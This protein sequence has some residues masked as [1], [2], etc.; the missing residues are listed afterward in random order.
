MRID[1]RMTPAQAAAWWRE[2]ARR[3]SKKKNMRGPDDLGPELE[4]DGKQCHG[5]KR[6]TPAGK[7]AL[8]VAGDGDG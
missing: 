4:G 8:P 6:T 1:Q 5:E 3:D 2:E 7:R